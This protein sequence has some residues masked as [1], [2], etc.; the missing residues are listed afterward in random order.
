MPWW[1]AATATCWAR[2]RFRE[3]DGARD[4]RTA[5][6]RKGR[7]LTGVGS[8]ADRSYERCCGARVTSSRL[9]TEPSC[10]ALAWAWGAPPS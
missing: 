2:S 5:A 8:A 3:G 10:L 9:P 6:I 7:A 1:V 4:T